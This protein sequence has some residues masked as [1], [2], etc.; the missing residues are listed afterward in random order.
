MLNQ[1]RAD[2]GIP[3]RFCL[4]PSRSSWNDEVGSEAEIQTETFLS[5]PAPTPRRSG[6]SVS[7]ISLENITSAADPTQRLPLFQLLAGPSACYRHSI[8]SPYRARPAAPP[9]RLFQTQ[10][11]TGDR[12]RHVIMMGRPNRMIDH[13]APGS[14]RRPPLKRTELRD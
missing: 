5:T 10:K 1:N 9:S 6:I 4:K 11:R 3:N 7:P 13:V 8:R 2:S 14:S 12:I